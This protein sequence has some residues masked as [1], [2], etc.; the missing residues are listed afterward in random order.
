MPTD[1]WTTRPDLRPWCA[2]LVEE[3]ARWRPDPSLGVEVNRIVEVIERAG[4]AAEAWLAHPCMNRLTLLEADGRLDRD[5]RLVTW[6][7][8]H[9]D[10]TLGTVTLDQ[11]AWRWLRAGTAA[12]I[13]AGRHDLNRLVAADVPLRDQVIAIDPYCLATG[14]PLR[15][16]WSAPLAPAES[17]LLDATV[18]ETGHALASLAR[19]LPD[20]VHWAAAVVHV[21][22]PLCSESAAS[23][24]SGSQPELPGLIH[25]SGLTGPVV[26]LEGLVHEAAHHHCT[27]LEASGPL[28][29]PGHRDLYPSPLRVEPRPLRNVLLAVHALRHIVAFYEAGLGSGL[30]SPEWDVRRSYLTALLEA[31]LAT[32]RGGRPHYTPRGEQLLTTTL[33]GD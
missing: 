2:R 1:L 26:A 19:L 7:A 6:V 4:A 30:L 3:A 5:I 8:A 22:V 29:D 9:T 10:A 16:S 32:L 14:F 24:S 21:I 20:C 13:P 28:I 12:E 25:L 18:R 33:V 15:H 31:G 17:S 23:W 27:M 11:P